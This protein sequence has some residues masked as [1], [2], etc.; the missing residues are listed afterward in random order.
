[1]D[2][3][4][5]R[6]WGAK[7]VAR[8]LTLVESERRYYQEILAILPTPVAVIDADLR[9]I[10]T[11]R[12][13]RKFFSLTGEDAPTRIAAGSAIEGQLARA[14]ESR[15]PV[16]DF[17]SKLFDQT[18]VA[19]LAPLTNWEEGRESVLSVKPGV[20]AA[21]S[22]SAAASVIEPEPIHGIDGEL[23]QDDV[24]HEHE[25]V[26]P[27]PAATV[28]EASV[29]QPASQPEITHEATADVD[30][31]PQE[32]KEVESTV[33]VPPPVEP[34]VDQEPEP[35][36]APVPLHAPEEIHAPE[37][38]WREPLQLPIFVWES[39]LDGVRREL[40]APEDGIAAGLRDITQGLPIEEWSTQIHP[41]ERERVLNFYETLANRGGRGACEYRL[42]MGN[43]WL[44]IRDAVEV[45]VEGETEK[46]RGVTYDLTR[47]YQGIQPGL[48]TLRRQTAGQLARSVTH[49][50]NNTLM[51]IQGYAEELHQ[52]FQESDARRTDTL[53]LVKATSR[54][55]ATVARLQ[56]YY[57]PAPPK[58]EIFDLRDVIEGVIQESGNQF[59]RIE[60]EMA[61]GHSIIQFDKSLLERWL[62]LL[63]EDTAHRNPE[64][65]ISLSTRMIVWKDLVGFPGSPAPGDYIAMRVSLAPAPM[66]HNEE[67]NGLDL[68]PE[69]AAVHSL[70]ASSGGAMWLVSPWDPNGVF[71]LWLPKKPFVVEKTVARETPVTDSRAPA[72]STKAKRIVL[73]VEDEEGIR[74]LERR[75]LERQG[76]E[77]LEAAN[78][79]DALELATARS[80][81][82]IDLLVTDWYMPGMTGMELVEAVRRK[83]LTIPALLV[84]GYADDAAVQVGQM[85]ERMAF[86]QK[87]FTLN[88][89]AES[90][91]G[92]LKH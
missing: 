1:M 29:I 28:T 25:P 76:F 35:V 37:S 9:L 16:L 20:M 40:M 75:L 65:A 77:V 61:A 74:S 63:L 72:A 24:H 19:S 78:G 64:A 69:A 79:M 10:S 82:A 3:A 26:C 11:N 23:Q 15:Q 7:E 13:F 80:V 38:M 43:A 86:L 49:E 33:A 71:Q 12:A 32:P 39:E 70:A 84:S 46:F 45:L 52:D 51:I 56:S 83:H 34:E 55:A 68:S 57:R 14:L 42:A 36:Q 88:S 2:R 27:P 59:E 60:V 41:A 44:L 91:D 22:L 58:L 62:R 48:E 8:L 18:V 67:L 66:G 92:L 54:A 90:V 53:E 31:Q 50:L 21:P 85:P 87:P 73:L 30:L 47:H 17:T 6:Q 89:L 4:D 81:G 5:Q